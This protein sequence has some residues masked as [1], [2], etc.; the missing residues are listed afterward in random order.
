MK[1]AKYFLVV[2]FVL[3]LA[4]CS[5]TFFVKVYGEL[6][7]EIQFCFYKNL[8]DKKTVEY[9]LRDF[10]VQKLIGDSWKDVW[11]IEGVFSTKCLVYGGKSKNYQTHVQAERLEARAIYRVVASDTKSP[12]G[13]ASLRFKIS[14]L[15]E[16]KIEE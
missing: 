9:E 4:A 6:N 15:G 2:F 5:R 8:T 11:A 16:I 12:V 1:V 13:Y 3:I 10:G 14:Q 7:D